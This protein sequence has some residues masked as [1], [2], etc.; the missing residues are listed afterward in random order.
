MENDYSQRV[1]NILDRLRSGRSGYTWL[2]P[3]KEKDPSERIF[4][5]KL[6]QD[7]FPDSNS[8]REFV[9]ELRN[10]ANTRK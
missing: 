10:S 4:F 3:M 8:Y 2:Y 5:A 9:V 6:I 7:R 1:N